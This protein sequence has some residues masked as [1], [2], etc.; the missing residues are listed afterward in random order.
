MGNTVRST[1]SGNPF[2]SCPATVGANPG[3]AAKVQLTESRKPD[4][5]PPA[6][7]FEMGEESRKEAFMRN[8][9]ILIWRTKNA[10]SVNR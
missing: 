3:K 8:T 7:L 10:S 5:L 2:R 4:T 9:S 6:R 1:Q